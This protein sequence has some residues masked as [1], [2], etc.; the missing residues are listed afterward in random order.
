MIAQRLADYL[1]SKPDGTQVVFFGQPLMGYYSI[2]STQFLA[3]QVTGLDITAWDQPDRPQPEGRNLIF[4]FLPG[5]EQQ[6]PLVQADYPGG[7]LLEET[8]SDGLPLYYY[9]EYSTD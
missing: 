3:P 1:I 5:N 8:A 6:I 4:V 7:V 9:Y 2:P